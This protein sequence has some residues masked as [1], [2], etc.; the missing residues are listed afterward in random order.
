[1]SGLTLMHVETDVA[2]EC[3]IVF[4]G[5]R[6]GPKGLTDMRRIELQFLLTSHVRAAPKHDDKDIEASGFQIVGGYE[7]PGKDYLK[8][9]CVTKSAISKLPAKENALPRT[10]STVAFPPILTAC[11]ARPSA[12]SRS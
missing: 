9:S 8:W 6:M 10:A 11:C 3:S 7:G 2:P 5:G 12:L 1:M 4:G